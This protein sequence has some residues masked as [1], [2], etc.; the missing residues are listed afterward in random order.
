M[1]IE[2]K[3]RYQ[4]VLA[5]F[6]STN[7][8]LFIFNVFR[9]YDL[10][11]VSYS[12]RSLQTFL[13]SPVLIFGQIVYPLFMLFVYW[14]SGV[15]GVVSLRSRTSELAVTAHTAL[16]G[17]L[18]LFFVALINDL[19]LDRTRDYTLFFVL[20]GLLFIFVYVPR[21]WLTLRVKK[22]IRRGEIYYNVLVVGYSSV[23]QLF[24]R[25][26]A[27]LRPEMGMR[28]VGL[29]DAENRAQYSIT[30]IDLPIY[31]IDDIADVCA[32]NDVKRLL[33]IPR[34]GQW[35]RVMEIVDRIISLDI[36]SYVA[37][38]ELPSM[39]FNAQLVNLR[40]EPF[41]D[42]CNTHLSISTLNLK[43]TFDVVIS[44]MM[45]ALSALPIAVFA[46]LIKFDSPGPAFYRQQRVGLHKKLFNI[47]KL[48]TM[49][50]DSES[51]GKP[52]L[53]HPGDNRVTGIGRFLRKY[54]I[55]ELPQFYNVLKGDMSIV[56]PRPER[57]HFLE[58]IVKRDPSYSIIHRIRPGITSLGMVK[59]G[60][61]SNIDELM[62]RSRFDLFYLE[63]ISF[64]TDLKIILYTANTV[65]KGRGV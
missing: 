38:E 58:E 27:H 49:F 29:V 36:P 14:L 32:Q 63:K 5:D 48:R 13:T 55:D 40:S 30:G 18:S 44:V 24:H 60:Y 17:T 62:R 12:F 61:A 43:R 22:R 59:Y 37:A 19:T 6:L 31:D 46:L 9:Y 52:E 26:I 47:I 28:V 53:S 3:S 25:Q 42:L 35:H 50:V 51:E 11:I 41:I 16:I 65:L 7:I 21:L 1:I 39:M 2:K 64:I 34:P 15:Y 56:G 45:L 4:Y 33:L 23:P 54:R 20:F 8:A 10:P 57:P